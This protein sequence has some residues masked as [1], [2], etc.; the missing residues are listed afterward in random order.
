MGIL[1]VATNGGMVVEVAMWVSMQLVPFSFRTSEDQFG[2]CEECLHEVLGWVLS[3][4]AI[5]VIIKAFAFG[6]VSNSNE[7]SSCFP[8]N[9]VPYAADILFLPPISAQIPS[10]KKYLDYL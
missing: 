5:V 2:Q 7:E 10:L 4:E 9:V 3:L 6:N 1:Q 8:I